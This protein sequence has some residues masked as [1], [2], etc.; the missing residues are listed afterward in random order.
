MPAK[1]RGSRIR[2]RCCPPSGLDGL[3]DELEGREVGVI[4]QMLG[5]EM[6]LEIRMRDIDTVTAQLSQKLDSFAQLSSDVTMLKVRRS[7]PE[8]A[9]GIPHDCPLHKACKPSPLSPGQKVVATELAPTHFVLKVMC[10]ALMGIQSHAQF[11]IAEAD[12]R[13]R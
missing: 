2:T 11:M 7:T 3:R 5:G 9:S 12:M 13:M 6:A 1:S 8:Q 10:V 4:Q